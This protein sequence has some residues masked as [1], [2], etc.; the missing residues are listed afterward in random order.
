MAQN[1]LVATQPAF[2][3]VT[4]P[5]DV[6]ARRHLYHFMEK[7]MSAARHS[8]KLYADLSKSTLL[9]RKKLVSI[10]KALCNNGIGLP[11]GI[12]HKIYD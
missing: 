6:L 11:V 4:V 10:T 2:M 5:R 8:Y 12:P 9:N 7:F 3:P 1:K